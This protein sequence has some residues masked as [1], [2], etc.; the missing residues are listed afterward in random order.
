MKNLN[1]KL[2]NDTRQ[3]FFMSSS[4]PINIIKKVICFTVYY[5]HDYWA[6]NSMSFSIGKCKLFRIK[7]TTLF[8]GEIFLRNKHQIPFF[9]IKCTF[10]G[11][12]ENAISVY[13]A[14]DLR[15]C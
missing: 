4:S 12:K 15:G 5:P 7:H 14:D 3:L 10:F 11:R 6:K 1:Y 13:K 9:E 2:D 8:E